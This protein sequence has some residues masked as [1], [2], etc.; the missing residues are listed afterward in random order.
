[1]AKLLEVIVTSLDEAKNAAAGGA[2]RL[3]LVRDLHLGGLTPSAALVE[4]VAAAVA[5]PVRVMVR[6]A[7]AMRV[8]T[9]FDREQ[10]AREAG[11]LAALPLSGL[12]TGYVAGGQ[13]DEPTMHHLLSAA[14]NVPVTFHRAFEH[15]DD[16]ETSIR[17]LKSLP[18]VDR[19]LVRVGAPFTLARI[20]RLQLAAS[21]NLTFIAGIGLAKELLP[22]LKTCQAIEEVHVGRA[23]R[24]PETVAG[25]LD[26]HKVEALRKLLA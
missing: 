10:L 25:R 4:S 8:E 2:D 19:I 5:I 18:Q 15:L 26:P 9:T 1:M 23:V 13:I 14:C 24:S 22:D 17:Q 3:E 20:A 21:P 7:D 6:T 12:V 11:A 16:P